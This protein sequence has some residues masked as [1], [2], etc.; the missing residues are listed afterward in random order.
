M[1]SAQPILS[2]K[3]IFIVLA[4]FLVLLAV[5]TFALLYKGPSQEIPDS[6]EP[7]LNFAAP[8]SKIA[9]IQV[10]VKV[11]GLSNEQYT[12]VYQELNKKMPEMEPDSRYF[13]Y[14]EGSLELSSSEPRDD[15]SYDPDEGIWEED[16]VYNLLSFE[17]TSESGTRY[18]VTVDRGEDLNGAKTTIEKE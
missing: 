1:D 15:D 6:T 13:D 3:K 4:V 8:G 10:L 2:K 16:V 11:G 5:G 7:M 17:M 9:G 14:E 18:T 12:T